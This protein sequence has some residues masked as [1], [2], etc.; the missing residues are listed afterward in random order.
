MAAFFVCVRG[1]AV[2]KHMGACAV[3]I[4]ADYAEKVFFKEYPK[5]G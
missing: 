2:G 5:F 3:F 1:L 4:D